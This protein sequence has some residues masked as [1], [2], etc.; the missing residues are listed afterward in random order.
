M[1]ELFDIDLCF[2]LCLNP[3]RNE[4]TLSMI[5]DHQKAVQL[6]PLSQPRQLAQHTGH[7]PRERAY[8]QLRTLLLPL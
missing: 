4:S 1:R 5:S 8:Q 6:M 3:S 2:R 7:L